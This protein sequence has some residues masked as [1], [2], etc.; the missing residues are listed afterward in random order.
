MTS[1]VQAMGCFGYLSIRY[2]N[3][4]RISIFVFRIYNEPN[5]YNSKSLSDL[6]G[7]RSYGPGYLH[8]VSNHLIHYIGRLSSKGRIVDVHIDLLE[9]N[10]VVQFF[11]EKLN[12]VCICFRVI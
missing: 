12:E 10:A 1:I 8:T 4:F 5:M 7:V 6:F 2:L 3:L 9:V 11:F